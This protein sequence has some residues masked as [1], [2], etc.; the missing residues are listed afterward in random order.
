MLI[1]AYVLAS[2][3]CFSVCVKSWLYL[4]KVSIEWGF[5]VIFGEAADRGHALV[6]EPGWLQ[7][8]TEW[9]EV[10]KSPV[11][12][13]YEGSWV[14]CTQMYRGKDG[15]CQKTDLQ[16]QWH[17]LVKIVGGKS[18]QFA[19]ALSGF[20]WML[21]FIG[22]VQRAHEETLNVQICLISICVL[23]EIQ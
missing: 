4:V 21:C 22:S 2:M 14:R 10:L 7:R 20:I 11:G 13:A 23:D 8:L 3:C 17:Q 6:A 1:Y 19:C 18:A 15:R 12:I 5:G 9:N 16:Q